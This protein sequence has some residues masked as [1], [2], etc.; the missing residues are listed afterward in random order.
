MTDALV[1]VE[2]VG[3]NLLNRAA[4]PTILAPLQLPVIEQF[5]NDVYDE[6]Y[7]FG[8]FSQV[9]WLQG[10]TRKR[11]WRSQVDATYEQM[12]VAILNAMVSLT[13]VQIGR[14]QRELQHAEA[15]RFDAER[16]RVLNTVQLESQLTLLDHQT[17]LQRAQLLLQAQIDQAG[18]KLR[19][20]FALQQ[21]RNEHTHDLAMANQKLLT[22]ISLRTGAVQKTTEGLAAIR[23]VWEEIDAIN[24]LPSEDEKHRRLTMLHQ[25]LPFLLRFDG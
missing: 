5:F 16:L 10:K 13:A 25:A 8:T 4:T 18:E 2:T 24:R 15:L 3:A 20:E 7:P 6:R 11:R 1:A 12:G 19:Q 17:G 9:R 23:Q 21:Q 22:E 14:V